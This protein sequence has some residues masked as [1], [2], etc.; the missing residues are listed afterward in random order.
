MLSP[1][2]NNSLKAI[3]S[4]FF[5]IPDG[6]FAN[7]FGPDKPPPPPGFDGGANFLSPPKPPVFLGAVF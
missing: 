6:L 1:P 3:A 2:P 4:S 7:G 5:S